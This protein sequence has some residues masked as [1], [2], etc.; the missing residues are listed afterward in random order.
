VYNKKKERER[1][2]RSIVSDQGEKSLE[3]IEAIK[4]STKKA[5]VNDISI[6][7]NE[8]NDCINRST[9]TMDHINNNDFI[10]EYSLRTIKLMDKLLENFRN[11]YQNELHNQCK[12]MAHTCDE[13]RHLILFIHHIVLSSSN[14]E[15]RKKSSI[16]L[17]N[18]FSNMIQDL[19]ND[20]TNINKYQASSQITHS[21]GR[22]ARRLMTSTNNSPIPSF[23]C[24]QI[25]PVITFK[26]K[27]CLLCQRPVDDTDDV[28][29]K[30]CRSLS[31]RP[32]MSSD[33]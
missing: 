27:L 10:E 16:D 19:E 30:L 6:Q 23:S 7:C 29:H 17:D 32:N 18:P 9:Q 2:L 22:G 8:I 25:D 33:T 24:R 28:M 14:N 20:M 21:V 4:K 13:L 1:H 15:Q 31:S 5:S 26:S 12:T 3:S 11:I